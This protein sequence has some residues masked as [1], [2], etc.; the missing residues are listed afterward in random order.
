MKCLGYEGYEDN[1]DF[2]F[3]INNVNI[4]AGFRT[5][6]RIGYLTHFYIKPFFR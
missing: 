4:D 6:L 2:H 3:K 1:T 5:K